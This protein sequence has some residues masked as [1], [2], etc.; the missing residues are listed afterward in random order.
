LEPEF[1]YIHPNSARHN[2]SRWD[3]RTGT[4]V[5]FHT[6]I[7]AKKVA[8]TRTWRARLGQAAAVSPRIVA[9]QYKITWQYRFPRKAADA[10]ASLVRQRV[11]LRN[12]GKNQKSI[13]SS[14]K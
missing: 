10:A 5:K 11:I 2:S 1:Y 8:T 6:G 13:G 12:T 3:T 14:L 9:G 7:S 4:P